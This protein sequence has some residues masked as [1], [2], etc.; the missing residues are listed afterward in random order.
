[1]GQ[2]HM[3]LFCI[4]V[5]WLASQSHCSCNAVA[6][7][8]VSLGDAVLAALW[9]RANG[10]IE[11]KMSIRHHALSVV[12]GSCLQLQNTSK[13]YMWKFFVYLFFRP[14]MISASARVFS[15]VNMTWHFGLTAVQSS[16]SQFP[17]LA[18]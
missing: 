1:M 8:I 15:T 11:L 10:G 4:R 17:R 3:L 7:A 2:Q 5:S 16:G 18:S 12:Y 13:G 14:N 9:G 6:L